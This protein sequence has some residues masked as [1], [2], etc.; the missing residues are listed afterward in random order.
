MRGKT[1]KTLA[2]AAS[3]GLLV[4]AFI[5]APADA[6][7]K[8]PKP[9]KACAPYVPTGNAEGGEVTVITDAATEEAPIEIT[10]PT[11]PGLG[12]GHGDGAVGPVAE[13]FVPIQIDSAVTGAGI[14]GRVEFTP[15]WDYDL[16]LQ[17]EAGTDLM[18]SGGF[19]V[20]DDAEL[21]GDANNSET[22]AGF[23]AIYGVTS[24]DCTGYNFDVVTATSPGGDVTLKVW[25]GEATI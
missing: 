6:K 5:A 1:L 21:G 24:A 3:L 25:L 8:K 10:V 4:G 16:Y 13:A 9:P 22:G 19:G 14:Y 12:S 23:E 7:K 20:V 11:D 15:T 18:V 17:D 2:V